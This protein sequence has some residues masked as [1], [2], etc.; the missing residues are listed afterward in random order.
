[1]L[2]KNKQKYYYIIFIFALVILLLAF[3]LNLVDWN[4]SANVKK[5]KIDKDLKMAMAYSPDGVGVIQQEIAKVERE[6]PSKNMADG[7]DKLA[8][9]RTAMANSIIIGD[10]ITEGFTVYGF[11]SEDVVYS[12]IGGSLLGSG[13]LFSAAAGAHPANLY[14]AFGMN[15]MGN[16]AGD[17]D[18]FYS[19]YKEKIDTFKKDSPD[20]NIILLRIV[21]P[22][23]EAIA[24]KPVIGNYD[25]FNKAIS[26]IA[27]KYRLKIVEADKL[28]RE[29]PDLHE[30]D[31]IHVKKNFY[32][33]LL[34]EM[35]K[36]SGSNN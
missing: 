32:P 10:S 16:F 11:L 29:N 1:M 12:Q 27:K 26:K 34:E 30:S 7:D 21:T 9:Y 15:D 5:S 4:S 36:A 23:K 25:K 13:N 6:N 28:I 3:V 19:S 24:N 31:G 35:I 20:T 2:D 17:V 22:S 33:L 14:L 8:Q 18:K